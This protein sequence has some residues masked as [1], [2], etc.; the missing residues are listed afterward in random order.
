L[1]GPVE[2]RGGAELSGGSP[3]PR[4][5][6]GAATLATRQRI[7]EFVKSTPGAYLREVQRTLGLAYGTAEYH[8][9]VLEDAQL[10][11]TVADGNLK[12]YFAADFSYADRAVLGLLRKR[13]VRAIILAL[14]DRGE[15]T[16]QVLAEAAGIKPPTL[17]YH[18]PKLE[19]AGIL[20]VRKEGRYS[21]VAVADT[22]SVT[23]LLVAYGRTMADAAVD[24]FIATWSAFEA[25]AGAPGMAPREAAGEPAKEKEAG[26]ER[27]P[28]VG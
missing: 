16:H 7:F 2:P 15:M 10:L 19:A 27:P 1:R 3:A 11:R 21:H 4:G 9:H 20:V 8:L 26:G 24:R 18:L 13:A 14:L 22:K 17:S 28:E 25:P 6:G 12:R 23:R 5:E